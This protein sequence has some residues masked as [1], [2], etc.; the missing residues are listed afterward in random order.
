MS[1]TPTLILR[2]MR[3]HEWQGRPCDCWRA[4]RFR[5][6]GNKHKR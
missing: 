5:N 6:T 2:C 4:K 3:G 1:N